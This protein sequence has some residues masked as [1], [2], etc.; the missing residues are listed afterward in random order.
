MQ[1]GTDIPVC[2]KVETDVNIE[3]T[4]TF[5]CRMSRINEEYHSLIQSQ[6]LIFIQS[7]QPL[8]FLPFPDGHGRFSLYQLYY[9]KLVVQFF[10]DCGRFT[11]SWKVMARAAYD[12]LVD[13]VLTMFTLF[14]ALLGMVMHD[15]RGMCMNIRYVSSLYVVYILC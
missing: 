12:R 2:A 5:S 1:S 14:T 13:R 6:V 11:P 10:V 3:T 9:S 7:F 15:S 4:L 8:L